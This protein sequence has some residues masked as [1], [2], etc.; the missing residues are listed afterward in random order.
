MRL[1]KRISKNRHHNKA[2]KKYREKFLK[3]EIQKGKE[4]KGKIS[5]LTNLQKNLNKFKK[6]KLTVTK[7]YQQ[8]RPSQFAY[9]PAHPDNAKSTQPRSKPK[10]AQ[11]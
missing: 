1:L 6:P 5:I 4:H 9:P 2:T 11:Q 3:G 7:K 10:S 8:L